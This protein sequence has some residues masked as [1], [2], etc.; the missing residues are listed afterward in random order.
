MLQRYSEITLSLDPPSKARKY[1][2]I[3]NH[4][5]LVEK[6]KVSVTIE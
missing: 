4:T 5:K 3:R 1:T 2:A 6:Q